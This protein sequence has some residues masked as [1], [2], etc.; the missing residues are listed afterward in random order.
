MSVCTIQNI[1]VPVDLSESSLN[2]LDTAAALAQKHEASLQLLNVVEHNWDALHEDVFSLGGTTDALDVLYALAGSIQHTHNIKPSVV[3]E[4]GNVSDTIIKTS[5]KYHS[6]LIVMGTHG[7]SGYRDG[8]MGSNTYSVIK[9][10][11]CAVLAVPGLKKY[12]SFRK[13]VFPIRPVAGALRRYDIV[14]HFVS[15]QSSLDVLGLSYRKMERE[16]NVL[17]K[18]VQEIKD[19]L[20]ADKINPTILWGAG[21]TVADDVLSYAHQINPDLIIITPVLDVTTKPKFVGPH[22]QKIINCA[23][24]PIL[25]IKKAGALSGV[26]SRSFGSES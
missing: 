11:G 21:R 24:A 23:K 5:L 3:Q 15:T 16:T 17:E 25:S 20:N 8:F 9:R 22:T 7:A 2:A 26:V 19:Q 14:C 1:L 18:I 13:V 4:E 10:A 6:N 12:L